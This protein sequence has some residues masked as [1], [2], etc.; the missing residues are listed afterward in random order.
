MA[1]PRW[2]GCTAPAGLLACGCRALPP[3]VAGPAFPRARREPGWR[4]GVPCGTRAGGFPPTVAGAAADWE[5][6]APHGLPSSPA[7][8][9]RRL[10]SISLCLGARKPGECE[11]R[12]A[13]VDLP[14]P[15]AASRHRQ[16]PTGS[17]RPGRRWSPRYSAPS[18]ARVVRPGEGA[19]LDEP[20]RGCERRLGAV[21]L[22][23]RA[24]RSARRTSPLG[25]GP[26][27][28]RLTASGGKQTSKHVNHGLRRP[29]L[30]TCVL[31]PMPAPQPRSRPSDVHTH[32]H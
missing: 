10:I 18:R 29:A 32:T 24:P 5:L 11:Q 13:S 7:R 30:G 23:D 6:G 17:P 1:R 15:P 9:D 22:P 4:S 26:L 27:R 25:C 8:A 12:S 16:R 31:T 3:L 19:E 20:R 2:A 21:A 14:T 28:P